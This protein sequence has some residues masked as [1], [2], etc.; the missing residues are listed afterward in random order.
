MRGLRYVLFLAVGTILHLCYMTFIMGDM[1]VFYK[2]C[3]AF[4]DDTGMCL[5][6]G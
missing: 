1:V 2:S 5:I 3:I 4:F 6:N